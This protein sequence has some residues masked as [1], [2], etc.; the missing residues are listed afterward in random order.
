[1]TLGAEGASV[2]ALVDAIRKIDRDSADRPEWSRGVWKAS[3]LEGAEI[4]RSMNKAKALLL[5]NGMIYNV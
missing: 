4:D 3:M 5:K 1:M 2:S